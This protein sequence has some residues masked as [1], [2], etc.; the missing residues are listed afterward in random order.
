MRQQLAQQ[1]A[2]VVEVVGRELGKNVCNEEDNQPT[3]LLH[4]S[5]FFLGRRWR[6]GR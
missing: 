4:K 1:F 5:G 3:F 2:E 6:S